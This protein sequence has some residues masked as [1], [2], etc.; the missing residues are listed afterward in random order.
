M[1]AVMFQLPGST[2]ETDYL[3]QLGFHSGSLTG[4]VRLITIL[5]NLLYSTAPHV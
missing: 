4:D 2:S 3:C 5:F 1:L